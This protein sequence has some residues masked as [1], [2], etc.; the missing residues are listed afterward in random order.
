MSKH[1]LILAASPRA[2]G[3]SDSLSKQFLEGAK[4]AGNEVELVFFAGEKNCLL[5]SL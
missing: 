2:N 4:A 5:H 1:I 3:N